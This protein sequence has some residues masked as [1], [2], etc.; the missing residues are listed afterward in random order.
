MSITFEEFVTQ[1]E[2]GEIKGG[3]EFQLR[4][5]EA[6]EKSVHKRIP[7]VQRE[8]KKVS[9]FAVPVELAFPFNPM[10]GKADEKYNESSKFRPVMSA[11]QLALNMKGLAAKNEALRTTL[12]KRAGAEDWNL[13]D[14][15][16]L[17]AEDKKIFRNYRVARK[18]TLP[19]I[20]IKDSRITGNDY[21][22]DY[23][24]SVKRDKLNQIEGEVPV[25]LQIYFLFSALR[26]R[27]AS[28]FKTAEEAAKAG[29]PYDW[30]PSRDFLEN[31]D[32]VNIKEEDA[33]KLRGKIYQD[34]PC[35]DD[36]PVNYLIVYELPVGSDMDLSDKPQ[37]I[38]DMEKTMRIVK[39]TDK[40]DKAIDRYL[41][42][43]LKLKD[44]DFN[45]LE[46]DMECPTETKTNQPKMEI[47]KETAYNAPVVRISET[48]YGP[49]FNEL[50]KEH[51]AGLEDIEARFMVSCFVKP[52]TSEIERQLLDA[53]EEIDVL[54]S[55]FMTEEILLQ[56]SKILKS[57]YGSK[58]D[59]KLAEADI[60]ISD[61]S[62]D[63]TDVEA[64]K[65]EAKAATIE[66]IM[67]ADTTEEQQE[68]ALKEENGEESQAPVGTGASATPEIELGSLD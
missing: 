13:D 12:M 51:Q 42:G 32:L 62:Q 19:V 45:Y 11:E 46:I 36:N 56:N 66:Q 6:Q 55:P 52:Y 30:T 57:I 29:K 14:L 10:T 2:S 20:N 37:S 9:K 5:E 35:S 25:P 4:N 7:F 21:G 64:A 15:T 17:T 3:S 23:T 1:L 60:G 54:E 41:S 65:N 47:P 34:I 28:A 31:I 48:A 67:E 26:H 58:A 8:L 18:F 22:K 33:K 16:T 68:E 63:K 53:V 39:I 43:T 40:V 44:V 59:A 38:E 24:L 49:K 50:V 27:E 61:Y